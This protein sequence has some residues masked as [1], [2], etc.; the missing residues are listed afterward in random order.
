MTGN[1]LLSQAHTTVLHCLF[2]VAALAYV[3]ML[4]DIAKEVHD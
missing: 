2:G 3:L 4:R 1:W